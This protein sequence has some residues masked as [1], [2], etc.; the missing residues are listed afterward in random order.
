M[1]EM[2]ESGFAE[3]LVISQDICQ[4]THTTRWGGEGFDHLLL[5][6][7]PRMRR[8]NHSDADIHRLCVANPAAFA[9]HWPD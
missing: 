3:K 8:M 9:N 1:H 4:H 5:R 2:R 6:V 7:L